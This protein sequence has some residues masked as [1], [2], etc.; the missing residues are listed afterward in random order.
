MST[1]G[2]YHEYIGGI[3]FDSFYLFE[4]H[5]TVTIVKKINYHFKMSNFLRS[6][7]SERNKATTFFIRTYVRGIVKDID[8]LVLQGKN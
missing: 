5:F 2:E 8:E 6:F 7:D 1:S 4:C 3:S